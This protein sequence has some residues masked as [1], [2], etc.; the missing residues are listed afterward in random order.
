MSEP[1]RDEVTQKAIRLYNELSQIRKRA[2]TCAIAERP[3]LEQRAKEIGVELREVLE[4][5]GEILHE[6]A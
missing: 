3:P 5:Y 6:R 2:K 1:R 4:I